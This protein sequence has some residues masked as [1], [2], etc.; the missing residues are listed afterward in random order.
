MEKTLHTLHYIS[1][2]VSSK[3]YHMKCLGVYYT[4]IFIFMAYIYIY[5]H[6]IQ[7]YLYSWIHIYI[8][9]PTYL[10]SWHT[11]IPAY[12]YS[13]SIYMHLVTFRWVFHCLHKCNCNLIFL[14]ITF[15][16]VVIDAPSQ[17][18]RNDCQGKRTSGACKT[19][20]G[21]KTPGRKRKIARC[22]KKSNKTSQQ[23][24]WH[25]TMK[26]KHRNQWKR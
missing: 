25:H 13:W 19:V 26:C 23:E 10:Y 5:I 9:A 12:T 1:Q 11:Y 16:K 18:E 6:D 21:E 15:K 3:R 22:R 2:C 24:G 8:L 20:A 7:I 14:K 4:D 17:K